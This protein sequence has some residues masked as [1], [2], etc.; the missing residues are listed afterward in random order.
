MHLHRNSKD[1]DCWT[2]WHKASAAER[3]KFKQKRAQP[4]PIGPAPKQAK[5][6]VVRGGDTQPRK[7]RAGAAR[8]GLVDDVHF[9]ED[10]D[11]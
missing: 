6:R 11:E 7:K 9:N 3:E 1:H 2:R 4:T 10:I 5:R 8:G